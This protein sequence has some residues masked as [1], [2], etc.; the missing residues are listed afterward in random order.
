M[1]AKQMTDKP[2]LRCGRCGRYATATAL[3][4]TSGRVNDAARGRCLCRACQQPPPPADRAWYAK[5]D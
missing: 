1:R 3:A 2:R 5:E 4:E